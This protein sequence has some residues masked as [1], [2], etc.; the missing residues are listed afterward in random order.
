MKVTV[1]DPKGKPVDL[2]GTPFHIGGAA[3]PAP[4]APPALGRDTDAVLKEMLGLD[5][6]QLTDLRRRGVI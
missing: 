3:L 2:V 1:R 4:A 5:D 6:A